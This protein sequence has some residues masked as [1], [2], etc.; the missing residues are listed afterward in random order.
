MSHN[1]DTPLADTGTAYVTKA[2]G[3]LSEG[4]TGDEANQPMKRSNII[5]EIFIDPYGEEK[6]LHQQ[7]SPSETLTSQTSSIASLKSRIRI[8]AG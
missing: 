4:D 1:S 8:L 6:Q 2:A 5:G 7:T 3:E